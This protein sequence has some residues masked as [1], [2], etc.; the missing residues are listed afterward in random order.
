MVAKRPQNAMRYQH[1]EGNLV[2]A[3]ERLQVR[4]NHKAKTDSSVLSL[5]PTTTEEDSGGDA[6][7]PAVGVISA[8]GLS[9]VLWFLIGLAI[10]WM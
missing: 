4:Q 3:E 7:S 5:V 6:L 2:L 1:S 9:I 8:M 10:Y